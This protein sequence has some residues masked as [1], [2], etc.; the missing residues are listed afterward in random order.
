MTKD[1]TQKLSYSPPPH[2]PPNCI[3]HSPSEWT[4]PGRHLVQD[5]EALRIPVPIPALGRVALRKRILGFL[6]N[7]MN[8]GTQQEPGNLPMAVLTKF[9]ENHPDHLLCYPLESSNILKFWWEIFRECGGSYGLFFFFF[10]LT[11]SPSAFF[12]YFYLLILLFWLQWVF[13]VVCRP[14]L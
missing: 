14:L 2:S 6:V 7:F 13:I 5:T 1:H 9:T 4:T 12:I 11:V 3:R 10:Y 8:F